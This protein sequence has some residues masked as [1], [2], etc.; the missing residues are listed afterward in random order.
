MNLLALALFC[1]RGSIASMPRTKGAKDRQPRK[2]NPASLAAVATSFPG[3]E[4]VCVRVYGP[5]ADVR[6]F[7]RL[8]SGERGRV[9][10]QYRKTA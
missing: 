5:Q 9:V 8:D 10:T 2:M 4:S 1:A 7:K 6:W 3:F